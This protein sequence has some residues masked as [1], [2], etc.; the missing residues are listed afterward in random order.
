M[1]ETEDKILFGAFKLF[2]TKNFEKVTIAD[3]EKALGLSRGAIFYYMKNKEELFIKVIDRYILSPHNIETKF[4]TFK[5]SS[6]I[7]FIDF[8]IEGINRTMKSLGACGVE[9]MCRCYFNLIFQAIQYY[10]DF[11]THIAKVF[12][13]ELELWKRVISNA[14]KSGEIRPEYDLDYV[15]MHFRYIYSGLSFEMCLKNGLDTTLLKDIFMKY[16][17]EIKA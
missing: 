1:K 13:S 17:N 14:L 6:L 15:A 3:L 12:D 9:N 4:A 2:L 7:D 16:Y 10:P 5:D 8:Y 11:G